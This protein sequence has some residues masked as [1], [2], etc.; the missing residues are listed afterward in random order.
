LFSHHLNNTRCFDELGALKIDAYVNTYVLLTI[1]LCAWSDNYI[2]SARDYRRQDLNKQFY[3]KTKSLYG[4][5]IKVATTS[6]IRQDLA[7]SLTELTTHS[8]SEPNSKKCGDI[9]P[10]PKCTFMAPCLGKGASILAA[11]V[12]GFSW[13]RPRTTYR[14]CY[15]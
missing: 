7:V 6:L 11:T 9:P 5:F 15:K 2:N 13:Y 12:G 1:C 10:N 3:F 4:N 8:Q 14:I